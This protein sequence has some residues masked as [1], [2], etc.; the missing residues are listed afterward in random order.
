MINEHSIYY[1]LCVVKTFLL[2]I[3][4]LNCRNLDLL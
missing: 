2:T 1:I 3:Y 4:M